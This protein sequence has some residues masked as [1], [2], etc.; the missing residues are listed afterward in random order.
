MNTRT[1]QSCTRSALFVI[2]AGLFAVGCHAPDR[3]AAMA[4]API[5]SAAASAPSADS[6]DATPAPITEPRLAS[7]RA[8]RHLAM[9]LAA[10]HDDSLHEAAIDVLSEP[11][12]DLD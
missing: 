1:I 11:S 7:S 6:P 3:A 2:A 10:Y 5:A 12:P 9:A 8:L 4:A